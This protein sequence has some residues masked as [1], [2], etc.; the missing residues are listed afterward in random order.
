[1]SPSSSTSGALIVEPWSP[2]VAVAPRP[3]PL[4]V[5]QVRAS[6]S[7]AVAALADQLAARHSVASSHRNCAQVGV[8]DL[9]VA[10]RTDSYDA[11]SVRGSPQT[12]HGNY[13]AALRGVDGPPEQSVSAVV[14][15]RVVAR[16]PVAWRAIRRRNHVR[17]NGVVH[18]PVQLEEA[19]RQDD[20]GTKDRSGQSW[21][22]KH[23]QQTLGTTVSSS[24]IQWRWRHS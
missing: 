23:H 24:P 7:T 16:G 10:Q 4:F 8:S 2:V 20:S 19:G 22:P 5:V 11:V 3:S 13:A 6:D 12:G 17:R 15:P 18:P 1:M 9:D 21:L 14:I